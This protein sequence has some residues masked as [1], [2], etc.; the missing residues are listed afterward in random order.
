MLS[1][2]RLK[3]EVAKNLESKGILSTIANAGIDVERAMG[4]PQDIEGVIDADGKVVIV[5]T[6]PQM[7]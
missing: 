4:S 7:L 1:I 5:Q 2:E 6:R 3:N